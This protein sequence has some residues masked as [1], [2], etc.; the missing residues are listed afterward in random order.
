MFTYSPQDK[1]NSWNYSNNPLQKF[2]NP[3]FL[4][5]CVVTWMIHDC[6]FVLCWLF[7]SPLFVLNSW[8]EHC[9]SDKS[10]TFCRFC[11]FPAFLHIW[12]LSS[13]DC[14]I[15][16]SIFSHWGQLMDSNTTIKKGSNIHWCSRRKHDAL[17]AGCWKLLNRMKIS[18]F[19]LLL[20]YIYFSIYYCPSEATE[21][22]CMFPGR[23]IKYNLPWS[24]NSKSFHPPALNASCVLLE[25][26]WM[27]E[28]FLIVVFES[29]NCPQCEKMDL[30]IIQS[31]LERVQICKNAGK[32][33]N[34]Q[35]VE[36]LSE[37]QCS[38]QL[39]RTNKGLMNNQHKTK[40]QSWIIQVTTHSIKNQGFPNFWRG[41]FE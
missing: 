37:E 12:T 16:R 19:F 23:Q 7:M 29:I 31:L 20:K 13:S 22:T 38:V 2:G 34:L 27:F 15:L 21:D 33:Q 39:F 17:R 10:S 41:L 4:I 3:W 6:S 9:S 14:M 8:T 26:Q 35:N 18:N 5:L 30:K 36:D 40:E 28:T 11:S 24:S 32:L 1:K 25:H